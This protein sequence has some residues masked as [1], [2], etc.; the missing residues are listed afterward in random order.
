MR[1]I[2]FS[3]LFIF[4][5]VSVFAQD[6]LEKHP[7]VTAVQVFFNGFHSGDTLLMRTVLA[8]KAKLYTA[9]TRPN[10][11]NILN[12]TPMDNLLKAIAKRPATDIWEEKLTDTLLQTDGNLAMVWAPYAFSRNGQFSHCG[13]NLFTVV[14]LDSGWKIMSITDSRRQDDCTNAK[15]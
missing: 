4:F 10:G 11:E 9:A 2:Q 6:K 14:K 7:A 15:E 5:S 12:E 8:D 3:F 13:A 1:L